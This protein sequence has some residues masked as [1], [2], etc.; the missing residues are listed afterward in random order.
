MIKWP[1]P[2]LCWTSIHHDGDTHVQHCLPIF[3]EI[4]FLL[5]GR[6]N[7][8]SKKIDKFTIDSILKSFLFLIFIY[9]IFLII[10]VKLNIKIFSYLVILKKKIIKNSLYTFLNIIYYDNT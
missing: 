4:T 7:S 6:F 10:I 3:V 2:M 5:S 9:F 1:M 8:N